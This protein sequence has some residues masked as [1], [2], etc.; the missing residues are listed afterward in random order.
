MAHTW[1]LRIIRILLC[2]MIGI[3]GLSE[4]AVSSCFGFNP[5]KDAADGL[6][7][8]LEGP[9]RWERAE[10]PLM[11]KVRLRNDRSSSVQGALTIS[12]VDG[13]T[14]GPEASRTVLIAA[15][16]SFEC[17]VQAKPGPRVYAEIYPIHATWVPEAGADAPG[18]HA[19]H[20]VESGVRRTPALDESDV[21]YPPLRLES[22]RIALAAWTGAQVFIQEDGQ[23]PM[24]MP[25][26]WRGSEGR[27]RGSFT[28]PGWVDRGEARSAVG[29][30]PPWYEGRIG[31][32]W[33]EYAVE[34]PEQGPIR[35]HFGTAIRDHNP[36]RGEP[37]S[38]GVTFRVRV[39][40]M[41]AERGVLG[42]LL[43][44]RHTDSKQW[45]DAEV[46]LDAYAGRAVRLQ[47]ECDPGPKRNTACD[48]AYWGNPV[49]SAGVAAAGGE[50]A[51]VVIQD[52]TPDWTGSL[53]GWGTCTVQLGKRGLLDATV[54]FVD[55]TG[56]RLVLE[57][58]H[59]QVEGVAL[60]S[61][62]SLVML[63]GVTTDI[64]PEGGLAVRHRFRGLRGEPY[65]LLGR[66]GVVGGAMD[67]G[68][69]LMG[70]PEPEPWRVV[71]IESVACGRWD[72]RAEAVY[73]GA[74][75]VVLRPDAFQIP[76]DGHQ[77]ST[78]FVGFDFDPIR[79]I[80]SVDSVPDRL[81][82]DPERGVYTLRAAG[83]TRFRFVPRTDIW[84][85]V[86]V[87]R[88]LDSRPAGAG[89]D[90]L[91][92]RF[93]F[94]LW[95]GRYGE[96][97]ERLARAFRYGL[98]DAVV[99]WHNWQRWGYDYRLPDIF[100]PNPWLGTS[101]EFRRLV[102]TCRAAGVLFSPHDNYVDIYPDSEAFSYEQVAFNAGGDPTRAWLNEGRGAQSYRWR[103]DRV[104]PFLKENLE[105]LAE[106]YQPTSYFIDVWSSLG[107]YD[108]WDWDGRFY[109]REYTRR[110]WGRLFAWIREHLGKDAPQ[111]SESGH[112]GLI[113]W[114]DGAT[115]N[116][117]RV[118]MSP[119]AG[120]YA[121]A[122]W[123]VRCA[124]AERI[125]WFDAAY[126]DRFILH[127]AGY[128]IRFLAGLDRREH[129]I[130]SADYISTEVLTGRPAMVPEPFSAEVVRKYWLTNDLMQAL[131]MQRIE[132]VTMV[133]GDIHRQ[134]VD[135]GDSLGSVWVNRD[136]V[137][138][139]DCEGHSLPP[140]GF[141]ARVS[142][143]AG[144]QVTACLERWDGG[145]VE[146][147]RGPGSI[148]F[149][150]HGE[151]GAVVEGGGLQATCGVRATREETGVVLTL[152]PTERAAT[153]WIPKTGIWAEGDVDGRRLRAVTEAG[154]PGAE[155]VVEDV[156]GFWRVGCGP[157]VFQLRQDRE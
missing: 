155:L 103:A 117:L 153:V 61:P 100:P 69:E 53:A 26:G 136:P 91:A 150:P 118:D 97:A 81:E 121:W 108:Y 146:W 3:W 105:L 127:G 31:V 9:S 59:V 30:H 113:G 139:W 112:D 95:G 77:L 70:V 37:A 45:M 23:V 93:V 84:E 52:E 48:Q 145:V 56:T 140:Y 147:S 106:A 27:T 25:A 131:A 60:E 47:L 13:W 22:G 28:L 124:D 42:A 39:V 82:V 38:D 32:L 110:T 92:G 34:L 78:S 67:I 24:A 144:G 62:E 85:S 72:R 111:I 119:D 114:L 151:M 90:E 98:K 88:E 128:E 66:V 43:F 132:S 102:E 58:F 41:D 141:Y 138:D 65:E 21:V 19:V 142:D 15:G 122:T 126:H 54:A 16:A 134:R 4:W 156:P 94:D 10:D 36:E 148:Y 73:A 63:A 133:D 14:F 74:G 40:P 57:G 12:G 116:H 99:I 68:F 71:R 1:I 125:P 6:E 135:W 46:N 8:E 35:L 107:P 7:L 76:F 96:S 130:Y 101:E 18:L 143:G 115:A 89:V 79:L 149:R 17:E 51:A 55:E 83:P 44:D 120:S 152:L 75:N 104:E 2:S 123:K 5:P 129:G 109:T 49:L 33:V 50:N 86:R 154:A 137:A 11:L 64:S 20:F 80:Q 29:I 157:D 87:W